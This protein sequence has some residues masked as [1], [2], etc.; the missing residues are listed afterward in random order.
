MKAIAIVLVFS[1]AVSLTISRLLR[2]PAQDTYSAWRHWLGFIAWFAAYLLVVYVCSKYAAYRDPYLV[3]LIF[4]C[5]GWSLILLWRLSPGLGL[6]QTAWYLLGSLLFIMIIRFQVVISYL[7]RFTYLWLISA[8]LL[9]ALTLV[10]GLSGTSN[11]PSLW[12]NIGGFTFQPS[13][14][15]K[16]IFIVYL[17][18]YFSKKTFFRIKSLS[19]IVPTLVIALLALLILVSQ[20]DLGTAVLLLAIYLLLVYIATGSKKFLAAGAFGFTVA[21]VAGFMAFDVIR[22][23]VNAWLNPW[24]DPEGRSYQIV[25][26][27]IAQAAGGIFGTGLGMGSPTL[28]P[29]SSSDFIFT[30]IS[31]EFGLL[32]STALILLILLVTSRG[33]FIGLHSRSKFETFFA[34]GI[35][36]WWAAQ[37]FMIIGGNIRLLPLTGVT[38]PFFSYGGSSLVIGM[39]SAAFLTVISNKRTGYGV[40]H[41]AAQRLRTSALP[42][43]LVGTMGALLLLPYWSVI[44]QDALVNRSDNL[45]R[46]IA[47][48][49]IPRGNILDRHGQVISGSA[50]QTGEIT[51]TYAYPRLAAT[52][53]YSNLTF[54]QT[55]L[56][57]ALDPYLRGLRSYPAGILWWNN[58][59]VNH[60]PSGQD[61]R[62]TIDL[63]LQSYTDNLLAGHKGAVILLNAGTGE[64]LAMSSSPWFDPATLDTTWETLVKDENAPLLNRALQGTYPPGTALGPFL[65]AAGLD[66]EPE[67]ASASAGNVE[68]LGRNVSCAL[69]TNPLAGMEDTL[70]NGCPQTLVNLGQLLGMKTLVKL[71]STAGFYS[72][73]DF[74]LPVA[75]IKPADQKNY[76]KSMSIGQNLDLTPLQMA[77][78]ASAITNKGRI[79]DPLI[80]GSFRS[81]EGDWQLFPVETAQSAVFS[82]AAS[83]RVA[84]A[85]GL[86]GIPAWGS[87]GKALSSTSGTVS[88][89]IGG[90]N[91]AWPGIPM[92][93]AVVVE[94]ENAPI[95]SS[96]GADILKKITFIEKGD[97]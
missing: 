22:L 1:L 18:A 60:P 44:R 24:L 21:G 35:S 51:R 93:V 89:F 13:E 25:Q 88:W 20:R 11:Q 42:V 9:T 75:D 59:L 26:A 74:I 79:P 77:L 27:L 91:K 41:E 72:Q 29:V 83:N 54:G 10:P 14:P 28:V 31:E 19:I 94:Q 17:S 84:G 78:A 2:D 48:L 47:D 5:T 80:V 50:G 23:R 58:L 63:E 8:L 45:R 82:E 87:T 55:G 4:L 96:I 7:Q 33:F 95:A 86:P 52:T 73:P 92:A 70:R 6:R 85:L 3:H 39:A 66:K 53:G 65:Y 37:S 49:Y 40:D 69:V 64:I 67:F 81:G 57:L 46:A 76:I 12:I 90:T 56:E 38:L 16:F 36:W 34:L 62:L 97:Q 30:S 68:Y 43:I 15:L 71:F 61:V 32:G